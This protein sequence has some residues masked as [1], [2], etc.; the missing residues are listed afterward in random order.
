MTRFVQPVGEVAKSTEPSFDDIRRML[1]EQIAEK[2]GEKKEEKDDMPC[3]GSGCYIET[4]FNTYCVY[5]KGPDL[6][7]Q[8]YTMK[9]GKP[10]LEGDSQKVRR[11]TEFVPDS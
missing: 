5:H 8:K 9:D 6:F 1:E 10:E 11:L 7:K 3:C 4:C 2:Y